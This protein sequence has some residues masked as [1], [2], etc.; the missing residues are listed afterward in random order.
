M[1]ASLSS[2]RRLRDLSEA[3]ILALAISSEEDDA[4]I[5]RHY[6][7]RLR[8]EYPA[9]AAVFDGMATEEDGHRRAL[10]DLYTSR[11]GQA[12]PLIRREHVAG[13]HMRKPVWLSAQMS[14]EKI[15]GAAAKMEREAGAFYES[16]P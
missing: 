7:D 9:G 3:E 15:R 2:R 14:L 6:A 1:L 8:A 12:I 10:I 13:F 16:L 5:Y 4:R 11:F